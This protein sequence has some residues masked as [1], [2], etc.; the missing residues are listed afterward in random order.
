M[1]NRRTPITINILFCC[2]IGFIIGTI[3]KNILIWTLGAVAFGLAV[4]WLVNRLY[5]TL[6]IPHNRHLRVILLV[7]LIE[8]LGL[9]YIVIPAIGA[10]QIVHPVRFPVEITPSDFNQVYEPVSLITADN[11]QIE[12]WYFPSQNGAAIIAVHGMNGNRTHVIPQSFSLLEQGYGILTIDM[13]AHGESE[14]DLYPGPWWAYQDILAGID[15][16][17]AK[18]EVDPQRIGALGL[19]AGANAV[20]QAAAE[21]E[22]ISALFVDGT[23]MN[24]TSEALNPVLPE[25]RPYLITTPLNW[26]YHQFISIFSKKPL[27]PAIKELVPRVSPRPIYF[28]AGS[29]DKIEAALASRYQAAA[30]ENA[31][32]W[33]IPDADH[34]G[35]IDL[36][37]D[38]YT[39]RMVEFFDTNLAK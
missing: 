14:G 35:G 16:L 20:I 26:N 12:G 39:R 30:T 33:I 19:S 29:T 5:A 38:E 1:H 9:F 18:E 11:L 31:Q 13:R 6:N 32:L 27:G 25:I 21:N 22:N 10:Y 34:L 3:V 2:L 28:V 24:R 37:Y 36:H 7:M 8:A 15:F 4:G 17:L 23:G